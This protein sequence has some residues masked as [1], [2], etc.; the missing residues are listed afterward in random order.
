[1]AMGLACVTTDVPGCREVVDDGDNGFLVS[2]RNAEALADAL[3]KLIGDASLRERMGR[4]GRERA[5]REFSDER[6]IAETLD[7]YREIT[8]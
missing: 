3:A 2:P 5:E 6:V 1:M 8:G 7:V 4:R